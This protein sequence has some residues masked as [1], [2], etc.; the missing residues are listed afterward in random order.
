MQCRPILLPGLNVPEDLVELHLALHWALL[1]IHIKGTANV[2]L[3][4]TLGVFLEELVVNIFVNVD[5]G[6]CMASL[7]KIHVDAPSRPFNSFL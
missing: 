3:L 6:A 4:H 2:D 7:A 5:T 1:D